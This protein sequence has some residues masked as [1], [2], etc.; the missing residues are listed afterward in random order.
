MN[1]QW[2]YISLAII[3]VSFLLRQPL[4]LVIGLLGLLVVGIADIWINFCLRNLRYSRQLSEQRVLF[5]EEITLSLTIENA[6][7][8]PLPWL[9]VEDSVPRSLLFPKGDIHVSFRSNAALLE[10][11]FSPRWYER[12]TRRYTIRCNA[13]G[14]HTFGPTTLR[15]G[16]VFG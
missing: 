3:V 14:V 7:L 9:E 5:G 2:Y 6:K 8:L 4:L 16:D 13:R 12:I 10:N 1:K 11:L 15:S